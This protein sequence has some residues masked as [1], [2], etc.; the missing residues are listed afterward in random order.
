MQYTF[1]KK[2][3]RAT[4]EHLLQFSHLRFFDRRLLYLIFKK[5]ILFR[6]DFKDLDYSL[7]FRFKTP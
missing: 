2:A 6:N 7:Y 1:Y 4:S 3:S 5:S